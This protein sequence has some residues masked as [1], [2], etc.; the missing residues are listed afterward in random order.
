M[1]N[2]SSIKC[3]PLGHS[4]LSTSNL[5]QFERH[6]M[7]YIGEKKGKTHKN[8]YALFMSTQAAAYHTVKQLFP[9]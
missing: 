6:L 4:L 2:K 9:D 8:V 3:I 5:Q 7:L 1:W